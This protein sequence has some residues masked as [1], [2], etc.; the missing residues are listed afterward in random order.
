LEARCAIE[1]L[2]RGILRAATYQE[3]RAPPDVFAAGSGKWLFERFEE[4][5][6]P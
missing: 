3:N 5:R 1:L 4:R 2:S 6:P